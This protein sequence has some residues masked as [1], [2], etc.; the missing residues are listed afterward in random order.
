[1]ARVTDTQSQHPEDEAALQDAHHYR[2]AGRR[3]EDAIP[4]SQKILVGAL[5]HAIDKRSA[6]PVITLDGKRYM[7]GNATS[8]IEPSDLEDPIKYE[9]A[10]EKLGKCYLLPYYEREDHAFLRQEKRMV[11]SRV[12]RFFELAQQGIRNEKS[13]DEI[14]AAIETYRTDGKN[15]AMLVGAMMDH[16]E[17]L[18]LTIIDVSKLNPK[19]ADTTNPAFNELVQE[20]RFFYNFVCYGEKLA[21]MQSTWNKKP[22]HCPEPPIEANTLMSSVRLADGSADVDGL[23]GYYA[24]EIGKIV[25]VETG[26]RYHS[27]TNDERKAARKMIEKISREAVTRYVGLACGAIDHVHDALNYYVLGNHQFQRILRDNR[28]H[29]PTLT[30]EGLSAANYQ[31]LLDDFATKARARTCIRLKDSSFFKAADAE[32]TEAAQRLNDANEAI[33]SLP[34]LPNAVKDGVEL[35]QRGINLIGNMAQT[36]LPRDHN[37][38]AFDKDKGKKLSSVAMLEADLQKWSARSARMNAAVACAYT[39]KE[40]RPKP[41]VQWHQRM[42]T[43]LANHNNAAGVGRG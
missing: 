26:S 8:L 6:H 37:A 36:R 32:F 24:R 28:E 15:G 43:L 16:L 10:M 9:A 34:E 42:Q 21:Y 22:E 13:A 19:F 39:A 41:K 23:F 18:S 20:F 29:L 11:Q 1:M 7:I 12:S 3:L 35:S 5:R 31:F 14:L 27:M 25:S 33:L 17:A 2:F 4:P 40:V 38:P 30:D